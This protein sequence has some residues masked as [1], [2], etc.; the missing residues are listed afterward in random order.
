MNA[1]RSLA[2]TKPNHLLCCTTDGT[3]SH[4]KKPFTKS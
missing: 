3:G 4:Y 2:N 1:T